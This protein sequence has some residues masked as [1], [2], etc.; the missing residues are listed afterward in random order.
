[1]GSVGFALSRFLAADWNAQHRAGCGGQ[2][3]WTE[4]GSWSA[5]VR[6]QAEADPIQLGV[7]VAHAFVHLNMTWLSD[8]SFLRSPWPVAR[9]QR[10]LSLASATDGLARVGFLPK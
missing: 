8:P 2:G 7:F 3:P 5:P 1:M 6:E 9:H 4:G 10:G